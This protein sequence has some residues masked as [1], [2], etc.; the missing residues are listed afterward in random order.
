MMTFLDFWRAL[1]VALAVRGE[2]EAL[3]QEARSWW[4]WR[5][6]KAV[7]E[8]LINRVLNQRKPL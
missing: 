5:P 4:E 7:D 3:W 2:P 6:V 1:N 8:R